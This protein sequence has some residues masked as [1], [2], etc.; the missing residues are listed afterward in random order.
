MAITRAQQAKQMLQNGG[1]LVQPGFGG[2]R[3]GYRSAKA[4]EVQGRTRD[5]G[6]DYGQFDRAVS[7]S[8]NNP[9]RT[10]TS[11]SGDDDNKVDV[12]FQEALRKQKIKQ[13]QKTAQDVGFRTSAST[14]YVPPS[15][16]QQFKNKRFQNAIN[17]NKVAA[18]RELGLMDP[19]S[20]NLATALF[21]GF[22]ELPEMYQDLTEQEI[23]DLAMEINKMKQ[24]SG[25]TLSMPTV[26]GN[27]ADSGN[28]PPRNP[29][30]DFKFL[31]QL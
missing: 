24:Y 8:Q 5:T 29:K 23:N 31:Y 9:S 11:S 13:K 20:F 4:Q 7:R 3:Q 21:Q 1:M 6:S 14:R 16:F 17:R 30:E 26:S 28:M 25:G 10:T 15:K 12:G 27:F 18:L 19:K 22:E 2:T